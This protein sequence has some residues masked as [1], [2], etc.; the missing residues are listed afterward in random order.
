[1]QELIFINKFLTIG[2]AHFFDKTGQGLFESHIIECLCDIYGIEALR[3]IYQARNEGAFID[4][5]RKYGLAPSLYDNFLQL[6]N[7]YEKFKEEQINNP[8]LKTDVASKIESSLI[9]MYI[10]RCFL[11]E[12][13]LE[14]LSH[15]ENDLLNNFEI[16]KIHFNISVNP[17]QTRELWSKKKRMLDD[18]VDLIRIVPTFLDDFTYAKYGTSREEV[19][20]MDYRMVEELNSYIKSKQ[21]LEIENEP[22][23][24]EKK[25]LKIFANTALS[26]GNGF[27]DFLLIASIIATEFSIGLIYLFL[28]L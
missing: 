23:Q 7:R 26:S 18:N 10:Y 13:S 6:T 28:H 9:T 24:K 14:E 8:T 1:M 22:Q 15:F 4:L 3:E 2:F 19:E 27:V 25:T 20:K 17:N 16:I 11:I 21:A 12:P 5:I